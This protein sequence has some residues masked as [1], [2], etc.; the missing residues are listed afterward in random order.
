MAECSEISLVLGA[1]EDGELEPHEMQ[2]V[3]RHL[4][5]CGGCENELA[6]Y[7]TVGRELRALRVEPDLTGFSAA[8]ISRIRE[9]ESPIRAR[10]GRSLG[11][12][13]EELRSA[14]PTAALAAA[15]AILTAVILTPYA[16]RMLDRALPGS[17][18]AQLESDAGVAAEKLAA[19]SGRIASAVH[20]SR[21]VISRLEARL[22]SVAVW[23]EPRTDTTVIW[24]T[25][26]P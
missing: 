16:G 12:I 17:E 7:A 24:L 3:A 14:L 11:R 19:E 4:A 23:S 2:E 10:I 15:V 9:S 13:G 1:F 18:L 8:V 26:Q 20:D 5:Q 25:E 21:T 22:P 6:G